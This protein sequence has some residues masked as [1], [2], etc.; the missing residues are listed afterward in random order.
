MELG[1]SYNK[2]HLFYFTAIVILLALLPTNV[3]ASLFVIDSLKSRY[4]LTAHIQLAS[5]QSGNLSVNQVSSSDFQQHFVSSNFLA[6]NAKAHW[7]RITLINK[8]KDHA[9][10]H[11]WIKPALYNEAYRVEEEGFKLIGTNG[12]YV[13]NSLSAFPEDPNAIPIILYPNEPTTLFIKVGT[14]IP[15]EIKNFTFVELRPAKSELTRYHQ[16][17]IILAVLVGVLTSLGFY[18]FFQFILFRDKSFLYF[19][20]AFFSMALYFIAFERVGYAIT[21]L[22][23]ATRFIGNYL[24]L[25]CTFFYIGFSRHFL[26]PEKQFKK[27]QIMFRGFQ[28]FYIVPLILILLIHLRFFWNFTPFIHTIHIFAFVLLLTFATITYR[29]GHAQA[30][31][32]LWVNFIFFVFMC[33]FIYYVIAKPP[34][35]T[36]R[37]HFLASSLMIGSFVQVLLF[38]LALSNRFGQLSRQVVEKKLENERL[39][40]Q[41]I[42]EIQKIITNINIELEEKVNERTAE[43]NLQKEELK[44]QADNLEVA[45]LEISNQ[46][47]LIERTH[48]QITDSLYYAAMI[49]QAVLPKQSLMKQ[50]FNEYFTVFWPRDI[51]SGDFYWVT[52]LDD[53]VL[54][55]V[56]DC[57][58]HGVPGGFMSMLGMSLLSE[59]VKREEITE[60][61]KILNVLRV[62]L[63]NALQQETSGSEI[64]DGMDIAICSLHNNKESNWEGTY[65]LD[66]AGAHCSAYVARRQTKIRPTPDDDFEIAEQNGFGT[67]MHLKPNIMSISSYLKFE[68][69]D[70][71]SITVQ[72]GDMIYLYTDGITDQIGGPEYKK[73]S[74]QRFRKLLLEFSHFNISEQQQKIEKELVEWMNHPDPLTGS[75]SDQI[76]DFCILGIRIT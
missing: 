47:R 48:S 1:T 19:F 35:N 74:N 12:D 71:K 67:L 54:F 65:T 59:I 51:V 62:H 6:K 37:A 21:G 29:K 4:D 24:A 34:L 66:F 3:C 22:D 5:D 55:A 57:T 76:D 69:F 73:L 75:P 7:I 53:R 42:L 63:I 33:F 13:K 20:L 26:D 72:K 25:C 23:Q 15:Q 17:W 61:S 46:K 28:L 49:Q 14:F 36:F 9:H 27:W 52:H 11:L 39:E 64:N 31:H 56:A 50:C 43:I 2:S 58:G 60:P 41:Q 45:Y 38:T 8:V 10:W 70:Q 18:I 68:K 40:K 16:K 32:Y 44:A 30:G